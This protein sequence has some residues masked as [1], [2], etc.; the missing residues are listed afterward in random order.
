[1]FTKGS[2]ATDC[3]MDPGASVPPDVTGSRGQRDSRLP[4]YTP[5]VPRRRVV[6]A[7]LAETE[8]GT[9]KLWSEYFGDCILLAES[10]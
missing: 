8:A 3:S 9:R 2:T 1:M 7:W 6:W 5:R 10:A 4:E